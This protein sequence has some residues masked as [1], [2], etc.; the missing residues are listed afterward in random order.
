MSQIVVQVVDRFQQSLEEGSR[1][2]IV[3][4][5]ATPVRG[6][7]DASRLDQ[8]FTNLVSNALKYS[9]D[10]GVISMSVHARSTGVEIVATDQGIGIAP[11][12][13]DLVFRPSPAAAVRPRLHQ[14]PGSGSTSRTKSCDGTAVRSPLRANRALGASSRFSSPATTPAE[15]R[16][17]APASHTMAA[18]S[19]GVLVLCANFPCRTSCGILTVGSSA[20]VHTMH[21]SLPGDALFAR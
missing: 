9:P 8:V 5:A 7:W 20:G 2:R 13:R 6:R 16:S 17:T 11:D 12:E 10:G 21:H 1:Y 18:S 4:D 19:R 3:V 14:G 15:S